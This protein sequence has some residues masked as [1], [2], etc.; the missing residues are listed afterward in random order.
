M[1][2]EKLLDGINP[3]AGYADRFKIREGKNPNPVHEIVNTYFAIRGWDSM[4]KDFYKGKNDYGRLAI[5]AK[6]LYTY[7]ENNL[8]DALWALD[9]MNY[10][11]TKGEF[12]WSISTCLKH[13][14]R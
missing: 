1:N 13:P 9:R 4:P 12:E 6:R 10:L 11:A 5:H 7:C 14:L 3:F 8:D 2:M